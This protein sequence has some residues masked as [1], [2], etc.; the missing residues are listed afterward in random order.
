M[1]ADSFFRLGI[2]VGQPLH[3]KVGR[4]LPLLQADARFQEGQDTQSAIVS[5]GPKA[6]VFAPQ[7]PHAQWD[8]GLHVYQGA[9]PVKALRRHTYDGDCP[10]VQ[11][12]LLPDDL[13]IGIET[14]LPVV[15][16]EHDFRLGA[17]SLSR[18]AVNQPAHRRPQPQGLEIVSAYLADYH[19]LR[20]AGSIETKD[21][22]AIG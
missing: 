20:P 11:P 10:A 19:G 6:V 14:L 18:P 22:E 5:P 1:Q 2:L 4:C 3:N 16:T 9:E 7:P 12:Y 13:Q 17:R 15:I 8:V 21:R